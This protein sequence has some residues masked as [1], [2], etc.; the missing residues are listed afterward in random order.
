MNA[1]RAAPFTTAAAAHRLLEAAR[2]VDFNQRR[3]FRP[4][5]DLTHSLPRTGCYGIGASS[6]QCP[7]YGFASDPCE[8][9]YLT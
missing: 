8:S 9:P 1:S 7:E 5:G 3:L 4:K 6:S 2:Q